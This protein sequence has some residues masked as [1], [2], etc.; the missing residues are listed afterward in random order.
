[1]DDD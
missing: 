1:V